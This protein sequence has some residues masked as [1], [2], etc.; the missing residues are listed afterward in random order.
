MTA[1]GRTH[2]KEAGK[3][4][5]GVEPRGSGRQPEPHSAPVAGQQLE[6]GRGQSPVC[7]VRAGAGMQGQAV[8]GRRQGG[9]AGAGGHA[10]STTTKSAG[11][12]RSLSV[13]ALIVCTLAI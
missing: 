12:T 7:L 2:G 10:S 8:G 9:G 4:L 13:F 6:V 11:G 1:D 3:L 5:A